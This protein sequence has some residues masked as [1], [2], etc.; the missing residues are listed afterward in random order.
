MNFEANK[1]LSLSKLMGAKKLPIKIKRPKAA[2]FFYVFASLYK[3]T[4]ATSS[5]LKVIELANN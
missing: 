1:P 4:N 3:Q 2:L 5:V